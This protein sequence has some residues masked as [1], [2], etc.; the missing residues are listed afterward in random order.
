MVMADYFTKK[1]LNPPKERLRAEGRAERDTEWDAWNE[2][3]MAAAEKG[4]P[5][6]E[7]PPST[8]Q[9]GQ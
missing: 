3:R 8:N 7:P 5:F 1:W 4:D 6:D 2:R 9:H